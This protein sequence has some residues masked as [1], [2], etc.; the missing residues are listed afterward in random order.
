MDLI[1][2]CCCIDPNGHLSPHTHTHTI[3]RAL[4]TVFVYQ[5]MDDRISMGFFL[6]SDGNKQQKNHRKPLEKKLLKYKS[7]STQQQQQK[8]YTK[9]WLKK[10]MTRNQI[11]SVCFFSVGF[12]FLC[13]VLQSIVAFVVIVGWLYLFFFL[14][15]KI[16]PGVARIIFFVCVCVSKV[17]ADK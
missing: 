7:I 9:Q 5:K 11:V 2:Q 16:S 8:L 3:Y 17:R 6:V 15:F 4:I 10:L 14:F 1:G 13:P 12:F